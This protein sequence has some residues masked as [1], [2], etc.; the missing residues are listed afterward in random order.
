[1]LWSKVLRV[2]QKNNSCIWVTQENLIEISLQ[3]SLPYI[4]LLMVCAN[5]YAPY[6]KQP[7]VVHEVNMWYPYCMTSFVLDPST[8]FSASYNLTLTLCSKNRK[9]RKE[10]EMKMKMKNK[11]KK[12]QVHCLWTWHEMELEE[13]LLVLI[14]I[15]SSSEYDSDSKNSISF[16]FLL[17]YISSSPILLLTSTP[18]YSLQLTTTWVNITLISY[19]F[20]WGSSSSSR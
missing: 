9:I 8:S 12:N 1:M 15:K 4:L 3:T 18:I 5:Y 7:C 19:C 17:L 11:I 2:G 16:S 20:R 10:N 14:E 13:S 6:P